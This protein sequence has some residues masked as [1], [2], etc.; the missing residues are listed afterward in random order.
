MA[1]LIRNTGARYGWIAILLHWLIALLFVGQIVLGLAMVRITSQRSAFELIQLHKSIGFLLLGLVALRL[2]WRLA[3]V[4]PRLPAET[5]ALERRAAPAAHL[6]LYALQFVLPL[7]GWALVSASVLEIPS[8][9]FD[10]FVM[11]NL[12]VAISD[13]GE[14][15]WRTTHAYLAYAAIVLVAV[16]V[17]AALRHHFWLKDTVLVRMI[18]PSRRCDDHKSE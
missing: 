6:A 11:P 15:W 7:T 10:L 18:S 2:G 13:A 5:G 4:R 9:P 1:L 14:A 16:H 17:L 12:P 8:M 3:N